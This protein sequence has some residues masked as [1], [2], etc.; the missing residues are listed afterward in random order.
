M[1][2]RGHSQRFYLYVPPQ[3]EPV[4]FNDKLFVTFTTDSLAPCIARSSVDMMLTME[5]TKPLIEPIQ[6]HKWGDH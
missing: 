2:Y 6:M 4:I 1:V 3:N 5:H